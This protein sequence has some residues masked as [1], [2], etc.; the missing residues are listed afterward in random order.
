VHAEHPLLALVLRIAGIA[1][2]STMFMLVKYVGES[3]V[4]LPEIMFWRQ[5]VSLPILAGWLALTGGLGQL[6]TQRLAS[7]GRRAVTG[8]TGM[9]C[10]FAASI[11]LPLAEA[12]TLQFTTPL[13]AVI[14]TALMLRERVGPW[15]W[16][17]VAIGFVGVLIIAQPGGHELI[18]PLGAAAGLGSGLVVALVSFQIRDLGRTDTPAAIVFYFA[19]FGTLMTAP[20]LPFTIT[21]HNP[22]QWLILMSLGGLG[23]LGQ[24]LL[25]TALRHGAVASV[26][27]MDYSSLIWATLYG[28]LIWDQLPPLATWLGA[29]AIVAAGIIVAWRE[30][31]LAKAITPPAAIDLE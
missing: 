3:G 12:T 4:A 7:H 13:F 23:T 28:W 11:L 30:R 25:T 29:P 22:A 26:I 14:L 8:M 31:K 5:A 21:A 2:I 10:G 18:S 24:L 27:V 19:L 6:R 20:F 16:T 1:L 15:R 17:A 9:L